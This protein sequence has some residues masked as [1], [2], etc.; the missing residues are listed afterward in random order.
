MHHALTQTLQR[1]C[2]LD[3][4]LNDIVICPGC[5]REASVDQ[6]ISFYDC[7]CGRR[8]CRN[9]PR[10][11]DESHM[12][13]PCSELKGEKSQTLEDRLSEAAI[14]VCSNCN[15][16]FVQ[17]DGCNKVECQCGTK[18][19][20]ICR[21][22]VTDYSHFCRCNWRGTSGQCP[23]CHKSCPLYG[24]VEERDKI[25]MKEI[26]ARFEEKKNDNP[27]PSTAINANRHEFNNDQ[28][29]LVQRTYKKFN[30]SID[31]FRQ[32]VLAVYNILNIR[33]NNDR[34]L[35][36]NVAMTES[37]AD[38]ERF[39]QQC[40]TLIN[41]FSSRI[42]NYAEKRLALIKFNCS[43]YFGRNLIREQRGQLPM[44]FMPP[45]M[46]GLEATDDAQYMNK[47]VKRNTFVTFLSSVL[48]KNARNQA[49]DPTSEIDVDLYC[50][51][52]ADALRECLT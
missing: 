16:Q 27:G 39:T 51:L 24:T 19:C 17:W 13:V 14:R 3:A 46:I 9:C 12:G 50:Q 33:A 37:Q 40:Q 29:P 36:G 31:D 7:P 42:S 49:Q 34:L 20:Y 21:Q 44:Q 48:E 45:R 22:I 11:Y 35:Y 18:Y 52:I 2:L 47:M 38:L 8:Q 26:K 15:T 25:K 28:D 4:G 6:N 23:T 32:A 1:K 30:D 43:V 41:V 5:E 10:I